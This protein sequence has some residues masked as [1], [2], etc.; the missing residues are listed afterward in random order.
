M[1]GFPD[2]L[3]QPFHPCALWLSL[4]LRLGSG[5]GRR[6]FAKGPAFLCFDDSEALLKLHVARFNTLVI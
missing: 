2:W 6:I 5:V 3:A 1:S 4:W